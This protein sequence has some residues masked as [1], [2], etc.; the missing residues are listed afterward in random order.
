[1]RRWQG[2]CFA[3]AFGAGLIGIDARATYGA[4]VSADEPQYLITAISLFEDQDLEVSDEIRERAYVP[5]HEITINQQTVELND[6]GQQISPHDPLLPIILAVPMGLWGWAGAKATLAIIAGLTAMVTV[7]TAVRRFGVSAPIA[8]VV[9]SGFFVAS[10]LASY[11]AQVYPAMPAALAV[12]AGL[13][14]VTGRQTRAALVAAFVAVTA[15]PWLSVKYVPLAGTLAL[16][17]LW[18]HRGHAQR[19]VLAAILGAFGLAGVF[20]LVLHQ[21]IWGGWTVYAGGDHFVGSEFEVVGTNPNYIA[22]SNRLL[23]LLVDRFFGLAAWSPAYLLMPAGLVAILRRPSRRLPEMLALAMVAVAW[24]VATWVALTMHGFWWSGRQVV[25]ILPIVVIGVASLV[26]RV[27]SLVVPVVVVSV[28]GLFNWTWMSIEASTGR[29]ALIVDHE[30]TENPV[31]QAWKELLPDHRVD[32]VLDQLMT[33][34]W[35]VVFAFTVM[36]AWRAL[37]RAPVGSNV[38]QKSPSAMD[39]MPTF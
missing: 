39:G 31:F 12:V 23:G 4:R 20:Y 34:G 35:G 25:P 7:S 15:L 33:A 30:D 5:F 14:A 8:G 38:D 32:G 2:L 17:L 29:R 36:W 1:M 24:V 16:G 26:D 9:V 37:G 19:R 6:E 11:G 22:R 3:I 27:R 21:R 18:R 13:Y 28:W 10:P